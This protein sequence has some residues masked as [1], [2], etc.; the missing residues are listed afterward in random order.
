[1]DFDKIFITVTR[2]ETVPIILAMAA[3]KKWQV[4]QMDVNVSFLNGE[5][6]EVYVAQPEEFAIPE[7]HKVLKL[8]KAIYGLKQ[9]PRAWNKK[10]DRCLTQ[11]RFM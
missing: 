9:A 1:M 11:L 2:L 4:Y 6:K 10:L 5:I 8:R 7:E 3:E